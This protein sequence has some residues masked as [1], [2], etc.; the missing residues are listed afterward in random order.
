MSILSLCDVGKSF[1]KRK[2]LSEINL[3]IESGSIN[4]L[5]GRSGSGKT[6]LLTVMSGLLKPDSGQ[7]FYKGKN[8][9]KWADFKRSAYR[10]KNVGFIFQSFNLLPDYTVYQN[11]VY[12]AVLNFSAKGIKQK[13]DYLIEYLGIK[14]IENHLPAAISGG[15]KQRAAVARAMMNDPDIIF[16]DEPTGNLDSDTGKSIFAL[17]KDI[18][19]KHEISFIIATHD[20]YIIRNSDY[21]YSLMNCSITNKT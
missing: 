17:F 4:S 15:E 6:T 12:P 18:Q 13:A 11:I 1:R 14:N 21:H 7:V 20:K 19:K 16:A 3:E 5:S 2:I 9:Y 8:I 10:N